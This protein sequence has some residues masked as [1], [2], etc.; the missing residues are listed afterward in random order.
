MALV[1]YTDLYWFPNGAIASNTPA[2]VFQHHANTLIPL[3]ADLAG[4]IPLP[5]PLN[6]DAFGNLTFFAEE[7]KYWVHIDTEAFLIDVGL[8]EEDADL[9]TGVASGGDMNINAG[10]PQAVDISA[11]VGYVVDNNALTSI[12][13]TVVKVD[14]PAQTVILDAAAQTRALTNWLM[15]SAGNVI[16]QEPPPSPTQRRTHLQ[17]GASLYDP[18]LGALQAV[19]SSPVI[20]GQPANQLADL[21]DLL[22]PFNISGNQLSAIAGTLSFGATA[23]S[24]FARG[25][26]HFNAGVLTDSPHINAT[27][28]RSPATFKRVIRVAESPLPPDVTTVDPANYDLNGVLTPVG[29]GTNTSTVQRVFI[30]PNTSP[31]AQVAVQYGQA[32]FTSLAAATAAIGI[33]NFTPN[34]VSG[35]GALVGY[36][37]MIRTATDLSNPAHAVFVRPNSKLPTY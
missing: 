30:V 7:G 21:M 1:Q 24:V 14:E 32:T 2:A 33:S 13:P 28:A 12:V 18:G 34:P 10:N 3:F 15:D 22:G 23:G 35:F 27:P 6:T 37:A 29:G 4:T 11:L 16:Q 36:I 5:N 26:N 31:S 20:L 19:Q 8:S 25:L 17:L 9:S